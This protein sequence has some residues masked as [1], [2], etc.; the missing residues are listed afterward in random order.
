MDESFLVAQGDQAAGSLFR[1]RYYVSALLLRAKVD[2]P[3]FLWRPAATKRIRATAQGAND[4][5]LQ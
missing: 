4:A 1:F 5:S 3:T 2:F